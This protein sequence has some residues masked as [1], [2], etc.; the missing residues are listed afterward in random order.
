M[1]KDWDK[2]FEKSSLKSVVKSDGKLVKS[3]K[4]FLKVLQS[5]ECDPKKKQKNSKKEPS[6]SSSSQSITSTGDSG[7]SSVPN[8]HLNTFTPHHSHATYNAPQ[9]NATGLSTN[10]IPYQH[11]MIH[12][13]LPLPG[14]GSVRPMTGSL[15]PQKRIESLDDDKLVDAEVMSDSDSEGEANVIDN[16]NSSTVKGTASNYQQNSQQIKLYQTQKHLAQQQQQQQQQ[17]QQQQQQPAL[18]YTYQQAQPQVSVPGPAIYPRGMVPLA[19]VPPL[20]LGGGLNVRQPN[21]THTT[22]APISYRPPFSGHS[23]SRPDA[24]S[25][26]RQE[27]HVL[28]GA[29][30]L[31]LLLAE[32]DI[33]SLLGK[34]RKK[35]VRPKSREVSVAA[36]IVPGTVPPPRSSTHLTNA[37]GVHDAGLISSLTA[38]PSAS[39]GR[40]VIDSSCKKS[41]SVHFAHGDLDPN[42]SSR[43]TRNN[44]DEQS[45]RLFDSVMSGANKR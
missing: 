23:I 21:Y 25:N 20:A 32:K 42:K 26:N 45:F 10:M 19:S 34:K 43:H 8:I 15:M 1:L 4:H 7:K 16:G 5:G 3:M 12:A 36:S 13:S 2:T 37:E 44:D 14:S 28:Q 30:P 33:P 38:G 22:S 31:E 27:E 18:L 9:M 24:N 41:R 17:H 39:D 29:A 35:E 40:E 6:S 11:P